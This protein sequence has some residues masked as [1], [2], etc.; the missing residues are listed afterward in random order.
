MR[1]LRFL[2]LSALAS[3]SAFTM[4]SCS[5]DS[6]GISIKTESA[7]GSVIEATSAIF[8]IE[9]SNLVDVAYAVYPADSVDFEG[10]EI[11]YFEAQL[12]GR[13]VEAADNKARVSICGLEGGTSY[14]AYFILKRGDSFSVKS[15]RFTTKE[16]SQI[17]TIVKTDPYAITLHIELPDDSAFYRLAHL[18]RFDYM[19]FRKSYGFSDAEVVSFGPLMQGS[20]TIT[21]ENGGILTDLYDPDYDLPTAVLPGYPYVVLLAEC[22]R[23]GYVMCEEDEGLIMSKLPS[24]MD[25]NV[26]EYTE[27]EDDEYIKYNG[28]YA[29]H[30]V[31]GGCKRIESEIEVEQVALTERSVSFK[32]T[33]SENVV[34]YITALMTE[35]EYNRYVDYVTADGIPT[36]LLTEYQMVTG[37]QIMQSNPDKF[38]FH[39][40]EKY[41]ACIVGTYTD[42]YSVQS[43]QWIDFQKMTSDM[44]AAELIVTNVENPDPFTVSFNIKAPNKDCYYYKYLMNYKVEWEKMFV[45]GTS[46][47]ELMANYGQ[48]VRDEAIMAK[49]NSDE[50]YTA[51]FSTRSNSEM[52]IMVASFNSDEKMTVYRCEGKS[53]VEPAKEPVESDLFEALMGDWTAS[54]VARWTDYNNQNHYGPVTFKV[55]IDNKP[56]MGPATV[57]DMDAEA[58]AGMLGYFTEYIKY[59]QPDISDADATAYAEKRISDEFDNYKK[60]AQECA[61]KYQSLNRVVGLGFDLAHEYKSSWDLFCDLEYTAYKTEDLFYDYGPKFFLEV[62]PD[63]S[64]VLVNNSL[65]VDPISNWKQTAVYFMGYDSIDFYNSPLCDFPVTVSEDRQTMVWDGVM[66]DGIKCFP[67]PGYYTQAPYFTFSSRIITPITF[68]KGWTEP[69]GNKAAF[70]FSSPAVGAAAQSNG[71]MRMTSFPS[72]INGKLPLMPKSYITKKEA[73]SNLDARLKRE[74]KNLVK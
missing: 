57:A 64:V 54:C 13:L 71:H 2:L 66:V 19:A 48:Y 67:S 61:D 34:T 45:T 23:N 15:T 43:V 70:G 73:Y 25:T 68:T 49:V 20:Q 36:M 59:K 32:C 50:G 72:L 9:A 11:E 27:E 18:S 74:Y 69:V 10:A 22:D 21:I 65:K 47:E 56:D 17:I 62:Q 42:D 52:L 5:D 4:W 33:P 39:D 63:E 41:K 51:S 7:E 16:Y 53:A 3:V 28:F 31:F 58:Y 38:P 29:R 40:G 14:V 8:N 35:A 12:D 55:T 1:K 46:D 44:P 37:E 6:D 60:C 26:G 24:A 30:Y